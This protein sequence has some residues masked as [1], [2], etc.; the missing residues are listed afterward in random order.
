MIGRTLHN[1]HIEELLGEGGMGTVYRATDTFLRRP[2]AIKMLHPHLLRDTNFMERFRNEAVLSAQLNHPNVATLYNFLQIRTDNLMIMEL[3]DGM[4]LER[5]VAKKGKLPLETAVKIVIQALDGLQHAHYKGILHRDIKPANLMLTH[6]GTVKLMDFGIA[7]MVGSQRLTRAD[8]VVGTLEYMA[9]ELLNGVEPSIQSDLYAIGVLLYELLSGKLPFE[10]VT[11]NT[12][13]N[14]ILNKKPISL[15]SRIHDL[16]KSVEDILEKLLHKK[17]EK[18]FGKAWELRQALATIVAPGPISADIFETNPQPIVP[19]T[20]LA[21]V[22]SDKPQI[23]PTRLA[24]SPDS[25]STSQTKIQELQ[26]N[27]MS[28]EGLILVGAILIAAIIIGFWV[29]DGP[30]PSSKDIALEVVDSLPKLET[31]N[32][33]KIPEKSKEGANESVTVF[34]V[35]KKEVTLP[36]QTPTEPEEKKPPKTTKKKLPVEEAPKEKN[37]VQVE[38][39]PKPIAKE[40]KP[41]EEKPKEEAPPKHTRVAHV[42]LNGESFSVEFAQTVSSEA[43]SGDVVWLRTISAVSTEGVVVIPVGAKVRAKVITARSSTNSQKALLALRFDAVEAVNNQWVPIRFPEYSD[44]SSEQ[45]VFQQGRRV[46]N[47]RTTR[48]KLTIP[49]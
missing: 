48:T 15:R 17:P 39:P 7:R 11:D 36:I 20:R 4:T 29:F 42:E 14:Q 9:P 5:L 38:E 1:Y 35:D 27:I 28:F 19:L 45:V 3:V 12:L 47:L 43:S 31:S 32:D 8:R 40:E 23:N 34:P 33:K 37:P 25:K 16:P 13:I 44:K 41:K 46:N 30:A 10:P 21:T 22:K 2:V 6:E 49:Y 24:G 18:R 26:A